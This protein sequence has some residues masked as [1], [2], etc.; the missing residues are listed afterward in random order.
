MYV[1][2]SRAENNVL[3]TEVII[4]EFNWI[5]FYVLTIQYCNF[6]RTV[7]DMFLHQNEKLFVLIFSLKMDNDSRN[8]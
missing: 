3:Q 6:S 2:L 7:N 8:M 5:L 4:T 1:V